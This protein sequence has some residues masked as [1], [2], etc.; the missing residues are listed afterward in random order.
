MI[1]LCASSK[2]DQRYIVTDEQRKVV[3]ADQIIG[4]IMGGNLR[5]M[6]DAIATSIVE[7]GWTRP[8]DDDEDYEVERAKLARAIHKRVNSCTIHRTIPYSVGDAERAVAAVISE[9]WTPPPGHV[10]DEDESA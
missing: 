1:G 4:A 9:G 5:A 8:A 10:E 6:A 7:S 2:S 3:L